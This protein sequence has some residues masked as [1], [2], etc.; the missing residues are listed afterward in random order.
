[1]THDGSRRQFSIKVVR[2]MPAKGIQDI[3]HRI[4][5]YLALVDWRK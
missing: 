5:N 1:M 4:C 3:L 2:S